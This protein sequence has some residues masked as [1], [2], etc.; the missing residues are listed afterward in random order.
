MNLLVIFLYTI[1]QKRFDYPKKRETLR[2]L[3]PD[4]LFLLAFHVN[5]LIL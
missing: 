2:P 5:I 3:E 4:G 1:L